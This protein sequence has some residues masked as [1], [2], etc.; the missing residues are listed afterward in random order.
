MHAYRGPRP[1]ARK[2]ANLELAGI[3]GDGVFS[4]YASVFGEV[5]LGRDTIER[6]AFRQSLVERGAGQV[7]MLYQHDPAEPIGAWKTIREDARGLYVEGVLSPG[8]ARAREVF[9]L[10]KTGALDGLSIGFRSVKA[11]TDAKTGVRRIL[12]AELWEISVVTFPM[13]PSARV[14]DVKHARFFRDR[15]TELVR[16]MRRAAKLMFAST[17][18]PT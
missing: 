17:F 11:R 9:S 4:G 18:K 3:T 8:V 5:D 15:E 2:F 6:G 7:R 10:M 1:H 13:L 14:S 12:E 16:Q